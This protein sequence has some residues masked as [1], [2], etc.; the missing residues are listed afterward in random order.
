[1]TDRELWFLGPRQVEVRT[2]TPR[3]ELAPGEVRVRALCSGV[4]QGT[5][6]LLY[7]GE[8]PIIFDPSL[9]ASTAPTYPRRYGY[10]WVGEIIESQAHSLHPGQRIFAL[11]THGDVH[12]LRPQDVRCI[13]DGIP[14]ARATL[15]ANLETALN[16]VWDAGISLGD[17]VVVVGGGVVGL[18]TSLLCK[19]AGAVRVRLIEPSIRRREAAHVLG[20]DSVIAPE[21]DAPAGDADVVIE[22]TGD[23]ACLDRAILHAGPE[24]LVVVASFYGERRSP[25]SLGVEF[26]RRRLQL[27]ASQVSRL[28]PHKT[29]RWD[30]TRRFARVLD[31]LGDERLDALLDPP[32]RFEDAPALFARLDADG[33]RALHSVFTYG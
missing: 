9:D 25:V 29:A 23:P 7:R 30:V 12:V 2:G 31:Y 26:H 1:M 15:A 18:L 33:G 32:V 3:P 16:I 5:E 10:A 13:P 11:R 6:L 19:R 27:K 21:E 28:P 4:S 17:D 22:A 20:I 14:S 8:G 24:A